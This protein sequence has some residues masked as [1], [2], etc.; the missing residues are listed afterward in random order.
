MGGKNYMHYSE[1]KLNTS[2]QMLRKQPQGSEPT[3]AHS[4]IY[5][6]IYEQK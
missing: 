1:I 4:K 6:T 5:K 2:Y 3:W